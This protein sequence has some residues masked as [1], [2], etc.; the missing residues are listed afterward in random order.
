MDIDL[1][2]NILNISKKTNV[3]IRVK[4]ILIYPKWKTII[5]MTVT[6]IEKIKLIIIKGNLIIKI[7]NITI[8][9]ITKNHKINHFNYINKDIGKDIAYSDS[10]EEY[11]NNNNINNS[12]ILYINNINNINNNKNNN[13]P[14]FTNWI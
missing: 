13:N 10:D 14:K 8:I 5:L 7:T 11:Y 1:I 4:G 9:K 3:Q 2:N 12:N 6:I